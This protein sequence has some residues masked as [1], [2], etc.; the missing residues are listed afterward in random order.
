MET[1]TT[2]VEVSVHNESTR[3]RLYT[4]PRLTALAKRICAGEGIRGKAEV[5]VLFCDDERMR[6]LN[7]EYRNIDAPTDVLSFEQEAIGTNGPRVL[8][9]IVISLETVET[10][11][12]AERTAMRSEVD[13]LFCHGLLH[14]L[15]YDHGTATERQQM[16]AKQAEYLQVDGA[17]A[18]AFGPRV[19]RNRAV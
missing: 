18:W 7:K 15:G 16:Q 8:G 17:S 1:A 2:M 11:C 6:A 10:H 4:R 19:L 14:L 3:R 12:G 13:L 5:S 9:D